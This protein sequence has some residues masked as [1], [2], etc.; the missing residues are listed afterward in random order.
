MEFPLKKYY[1]LVIGL[2]CTLLSTQVVAEI[3]IGFVNAVKIMDSAPQVGVANRRLEQ[4][5]APRQRRISNMRQEIRSMEERLAIDVD[6]MSEG[7][8]REFNRDIISKRRELQRLQDEFR[9]DYNMRRNEELDKLQRKIIEVIQRLAKNERY[10]IILSD[11]VV[12][13]NDS[14]DITNKVL[15]QLE[16]EIR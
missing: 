10:D 5:F 3:K 11:G 7:Q 8:A 9:E 2:V 13:A 15:R 16:N 6:I 14:V 1:I 12:W 4:E